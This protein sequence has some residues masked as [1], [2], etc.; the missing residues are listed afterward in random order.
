MSKVNKLGQYKGIEVNVEKH[1]A[2]KEEV[3][4]QV[5]ALVAQNPTLV[6]KDGEVAHGDITTI[7]FEGFKDGV[8]F[9][10]GKAEGHQLEIGSGQFIPGFEDQMIGMKKGE[11]RDLNLT[12][13]EDYGMQDLAGADV[14]FKVKLHKIEN[15]Q[16]SELNDEFVAS[17]NLPNMQTVEDL[18]KQME[19]YIQSQHDQTYRTSVENAIFE[20][21]LDDSDVEVG[22]ED[23]EKAMNEH[24][25]HLRNELARQGM[26]LEQYLQMTGASEDMLRQQLEPAAKQQAKFEAIIDEIVKVE[27]LT[28]SDEELDQQIEAIANQNQMTVEQV[29]EQINK[30]ALRHDYNR[31]KASQLVIQSA[32][33]NG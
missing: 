5:Q 31:V 10:G 17:L 15:K 19:A 16:E 30:E 26:T 33:I 6:E 13:P 23:V 22:D 3:E 29:L 12:F 2:T 11:T 25:N 20:K 18:H 4:Q 8:A 7:D 28:T 21:L 24:M 14:V 1:I 32:Q 27:N 9:D